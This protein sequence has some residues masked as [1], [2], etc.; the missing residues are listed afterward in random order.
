MR[1]FHVHSNVKGIKSALPFSNVKNQAGAIKASGL[2]AL[3]HLE[4]GLGAAG[5]ATPL[6]CLSKMP[7]INGQI[8]KYKEGP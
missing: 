5:Q 7:I 8:A 3:L 6:F 2:H 1:F 4:Q